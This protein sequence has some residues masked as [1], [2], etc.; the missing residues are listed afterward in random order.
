VIPGTTQAV[1]LARGLGKR[2]RAPSMEG[3]ALSPA[4][5][6]AADAGAKGM[7]PIGRPFLDYVI[8]ALADGGITDVV[9]VVG[10][11][12][13]DVRE[14]FTRTVPPTRVRISFAEQVE[15]K[16]TADA[17][18]AAERSVG[19]APFLVL[20]AD[21]LYPASAVR[22]LAAIGGNGLVCFDAD[23]LVRESNIDAGRVLRFAL[24]DVDA[25][26]WLVDIVEKPAADHSL[27]LA[28]ERLVSMNLWS[29]TPEFFEACRRTMPSARGELE[30]QTAV[31][32][33]MRDLGLRFRAVRSRGGVLDL[34]SRADVARV[35]ERLKGVDAHP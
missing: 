18:L 25:D 8:S 3:G 7:I 19:S 26:G 35:A 20:N 5:Q 17:V 13:R 21:N 2:M 9:L 10:A 32:I 29:F 6:R 30:I 34:S 11:E 14:Y 1:I 23:A 12:Q 22:D 4:Q 33:A 27:A 24:C 28:A 15:A 16:G 31:T